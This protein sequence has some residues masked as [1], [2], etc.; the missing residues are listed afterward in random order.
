MVAV[1]P[2]GDESD[3]E[4]DDDPSPEDVRT[5]VEWATKTDN[6][7]LADFDFEVDGEV[8]PH[9]QLLND[10][11][12]NLTKMTDAR[13]EAARDVLEEY[14]T[15]KDEVESTHLTVTVDTDT[16]EH[17]QL[18]EDLLGEVYNASLADVEEIRRSTVTAVDE[19]EHAH[20]DELASDPEEFRSETEFIGYRDGEMGGY[21][22]LA[23]EINLNAV[24]IGLGLENI[25][26]EPERF[27]GVVYRYDHPEAT[28]LIFN[29]GQIVTVDADDEE[30]ARGAVVGAV[31]RLSEVELYEGEVPTESD[32]EVSSTSGV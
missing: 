23:E 10:L 6:I 2:T 18:V 22:D 16:E 21:V 29:D 26:Y 24:A 4:I 11:T 1:G 14:E 3:A 12:Y 7:E 19:V 27:P 5:T 17:K 31:S 32:V 9:L 30:A 15:E 8:G 20:V 13:M 28:V 25:E